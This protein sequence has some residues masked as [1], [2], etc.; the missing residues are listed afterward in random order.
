MGGL[1]ALNSNIALLGD[2]IQIGR[3]TF[4]LNNFWMIFGGLISL[5]AA[6][7]TALI[8]NRAQTAPANVSRAWRFTS[9]SIGILNFTFYLALLVSKG[10]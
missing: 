1:Q 5:F 3:F 8:V 6:L 10:V 9:Y 2:V 7:F 4:Q